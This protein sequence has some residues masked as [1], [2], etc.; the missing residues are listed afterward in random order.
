MAFRAR[1]LVHGRVQG[2][3][4]RWLVQEAA[5]EL[6]LKGWVKNLPDGSVEILCESETEKAY[7]DFLKRI[8]VADNVRKVDRLEILEFEKNAEPRH[9]HFAIEY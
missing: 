1:L 3:N 8:E 5:K 7:R 4:Y 2:V 6:G 9:T